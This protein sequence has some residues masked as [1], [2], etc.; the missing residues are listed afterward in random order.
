MEIV[1]KFNNDMIIDYS[2]LEST[3]YLIEFSKR[4]YEITLLLKLMESAMILQEHRN[5]YY[6]RFTCWKDYINID[7]IKII[8]DI[9]KYKT[10]TEYIQANGINMY[11]FLIMPLYAAKTKFQPK[12][13][14]A[15]IN[16]SQYMI[17]DQSYDAPHVSHAPQACDAAAM[18]NKPVTTNKNNSHSTTHAACGSVEAD[19]NEKKYLYHGSN[20]G[21]WYSILI[22]G[23]Q[24]CSDTLLQQNGK[25]FGKGIYLTDN[26][27]YAIHYSKP[28]AKR[29][30]YYILGVFETDTN[31]CKNYLKSMN[32]YVLPDNS[33]L[34]LKYFLEFD[35][36]ININIFKRFDDYFKNEIKNTS[37]VVKTIFS[38]RL[39][40]EYGNII[41]NPDIIVNM[42][43]EDIS[44]WNV[45]I[46]INK[47]EDEDLYNDLVARNI[48][49]IELEMSFPKEYPFEPPFIRITSPRFKS[50]TGHITNGGSICTDL[51]TKTGWSA[52][53]CV[54]SIIISVKNLIIEGKGRLGNSWSTRYTM[55]EAR[56]AF[57]TMLKVH[58]WI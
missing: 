27:L 24:A 31:Y 19:A 30:N 4:K 32:I 34:K 36:T 45:F 50:I 9:K 20:S 40:L 52:S 41:K 35:N 2:L 56:G 46:K 42:K 33:H 58:G 7:Y 18:S 37:C 25:A 5:I 1:N 54:E 11:K 15:R 13:I 55:N 48:K 28:A 44:T 47:D 39:H 38:K 23:I 21:N 12:E 53:Y 22:N 16:V 57:S 6:P 17:I 10:D 14:V 49:F 26:I 43:D 29:N 8:E 51:L 3:N